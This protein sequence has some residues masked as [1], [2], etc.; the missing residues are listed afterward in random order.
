MGFDI[1]ESEFEK[2][3]HGKIDKQDIVLPTIGL[4]PRHVSKVTSNFA[5]ASEPDARA[6]YS[7]DAYY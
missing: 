1:D 2:L 6:V 5:R 7:P 3:K 4:L